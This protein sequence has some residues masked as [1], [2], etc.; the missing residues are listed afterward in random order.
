MHFFET[1]NAVLRPDESFKFSVT[2]MKDGQVELI[3]YPLLGDAP[4]DADEDAQQ[5]RA[6]LAAP[7][8]MLATGRLLDD[9]FQARF[10][11][12][13]RARAPIADSLDQLMAMLN[14][15]GKAARNTVSARATAGKAKTAAAA[16]ADTP[17]VDAP[18]ETTSSAAATAPALQPLPASDNPQSIL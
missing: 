14:D 18:G 5:M 7:F 4:D 13:V 16:A 9:A 1:I 8:R 17:A 2:R 6:S 11:A 15:A 3:A 10:Q 12:Y